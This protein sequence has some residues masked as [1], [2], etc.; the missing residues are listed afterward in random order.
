M[1]REDIFSDPK[2]EKI[3]ELPGA[4]APGPHQLARILD[5]GIKADRCLQWLEKA[6]SQTPNLKK[7][8]ELPGSTGPVPHYLTWILDRGLKTDLWLQWLE[9]ASCQTRNLK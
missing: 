5:R 7:I 9:K 6:S 4:T 2:F 3:T 8:V 1:A